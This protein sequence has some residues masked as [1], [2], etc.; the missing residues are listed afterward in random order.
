MLWMEFLLPYEVEAFETKFCW[1]SKPRLWIP[2][3][4]SVR[5]VEL[6]YFLICL[7]SKNK[8]ISWRFSLKFFSKFPQIAKVWLGDLTETISKMYLDIIRKSNSNKTFQHWTPILEWGFISISKWWSIR[9][10]Y[11]CFYRCFPDTCHY[12]PLKNVT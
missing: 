4:I 9:I 8:F 1:T 2:C 7:G 11:S 5:P 6:H 12:N 3:Y 10:F